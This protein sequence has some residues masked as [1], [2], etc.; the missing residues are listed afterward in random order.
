MIHLPTQLKFPAGQARP[1]QH[2]VSSAG[3][4]ALAAAGPIPTIQNDK[5]KASVIVLQ[6]I[7]LSVSTGL[8]F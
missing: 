3:P 1:P 6:N 8:S 7:I 4:E 5:R 2:S